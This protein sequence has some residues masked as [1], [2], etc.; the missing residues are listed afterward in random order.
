M[1]R[2]KGERQQMDEA[3]SAFNTLYIGY[4]T[5]NPNV[6]DSSSPFSCRNLFVPDDNLIMVSFKELNPDY[7][8][9][10]LKELP[11]DM[12]SFLNTTDVHVHTIPFIWKRQIDIHSDFVQLR[13]VRQVSLEVF[14]PNC[15]N[16]AC[17]RLYFTFLPEDKK[18]EKLANGFWNCSVE[19]Y[20]RFHH[21]LACNLKTECE[22]GR[23]ETGDCPYSSPHCNGLIALC[24]RCYTVVT[25]V[26]DLSSFKTDVNKMEQQN[27]FINLRGHL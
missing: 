24:G 6:S 17:F 9:I 23:D 11:C 13:N 21:H 27:L 3:S 18:P 10:N 25:N 5:W 19:H 7:S 20:A 22:D 12:D 1:P 14:V 8:G 2:S 16:T 4:M 26:N 15:V